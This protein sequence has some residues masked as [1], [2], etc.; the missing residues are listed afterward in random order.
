MSRRIQGLYDYEIAP[1]GNPFKTSKSC[2][3]GWERGLI[4]ITTYFQELFDLFVANKM[5]QQKQTNVP[6]Q[7]TLRYLQLNGKQLS[8]NRLSYIIN[9]YHILD[10]TST[11]SPANTKTTPNPVEAIPLQ[12]RWTWSLATLASSLVLADMVWEGRGPVVM[13]AAYERGKFN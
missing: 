11:K 3:M 7:Q 9:Y 4:F 6:V 12:G 2:G 10:I 13:V 8:L 1:Y 5:I